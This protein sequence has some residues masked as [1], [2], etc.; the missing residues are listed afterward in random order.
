MPSRSATA[1][2]SSGWRASISSSSRRAS[3]T[4]S[5]GDGVH[6]AARAS[7]MAWTASSSPRISADRARCV[8]RASPHAAGELPQDADD[9]ARAPRPAAT[10]M[11][12]FSSTAGMRLD[13]QRS[14]PS[15][16]CRG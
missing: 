5:G 3:D 16:S 7:A 9:L 10:T 14:P 6:V 11:S 8:G 1:G 2:M 15:P 12:L 4:I 13:E